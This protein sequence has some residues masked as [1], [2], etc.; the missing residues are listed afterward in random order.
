MKFKYIFTLLFFVTFGFVTFGQENIEET[1]N[2][3][4][5][6]N[7]DFTYQMKYELNDFIRKMKNEK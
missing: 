6:L 5:D 1:N 7:N 4:K 3:S 2:S